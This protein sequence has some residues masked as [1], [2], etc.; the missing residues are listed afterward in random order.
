MFLLNVDFCLQVYTVLKPR[1]TTS[2]SVLIS[3]ITNLW[4]SI[5]LKGQLI[6]R[7][8]RFCVMTTLFRHD[9][10]SKALL[11]KTNI[12]VGTYIEFAWSGLVR[13]FFMFPKQKLYISRAL[14]DRSTTIILKDLRKNYFQSSYHRRSRACSKSEGAYTERDHT[15]WWYT[16]SDLFYLSGLFKSQP[17]TN[18][19]LRHKK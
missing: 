9:I 4:L 12:D 10:S 14:N 13:M 8:S 3:G 5:R 1:E 15:Q 11:T 17:N 7:A 2:M 18:H 19:V 6:G 16:V